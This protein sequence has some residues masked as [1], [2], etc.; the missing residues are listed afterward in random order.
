MPIQLG[1]L[2][3][4]LPRLTF[5]SAVAAGLSPC[6]GQNA[7]V[8]KQM[9]QDRPR[10]QACAPPAPPQHDASKISRAPRRFYFLPFPSLL[11]SAVSTV[12]SFPQVSSLPVP[13]S[14][15]PLSSLRSRNGTAPPAGLFAAWRAAVSFYRGRRT[16]G[17]RLRPRRSAFR[18][19][20]R[21]PSRNRTNR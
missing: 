21:W 16:S 11:D 7:A 12:F 20:R 13:S 9:R 1:L 17:I 15:P 18:P 3:D 8:R 10:T 6:L 5:R 14:V 2:R 19:A 4:S